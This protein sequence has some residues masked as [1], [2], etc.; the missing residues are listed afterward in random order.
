MNRDLARE[1]LEMEFKER[2][3]Q[4]MTGVGKVCVQP[5]SLGIYI[6]TPS[7]LS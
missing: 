3:Y 5:V 1:R 6:V 4:I 2:E 7:S